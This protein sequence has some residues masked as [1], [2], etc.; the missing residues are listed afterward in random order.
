M[1]TQTIFAAPMVGALSAEHRHRVGRRTEARRGRHGF[2][3]PDSAWPSRPLPPDRSTRS[4]R[5]S[6]R[7]MPS[8]ARR[9]S[10][11]SPCI[12][13]RAVERVAVL[14]ASAAAGPASARRSGRSKAS[15]ILARSSRRCSA[16]RGCGSRGRDRRRSRSLRLFVAERAG[17]GGGRPA[18]G[19]HARPPP[20]RAGPPGRAAGASG[21]R[22]GDDRAA[23][24][25]AGGRSE[26]AVR[27]AA[28]APA[29]AAAGPSAIRST[30]S[31]GP[32]TRRC[33]T[34]RTRCGWPSPQAGGIAPLPHLLE[35]VER[36]A[37]TR[38]SAAAGR[39]G[40][41]WAPVRGAAHVALAEARQPARRLRPEGV[42][43]AGARAAAGRIPDGA[44]ARRRRLV[45][46]G[47]RGGAR[48]RARRVVARSSGGRVSR[49]RRARERSRGATR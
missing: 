36:V 40:D 17:S 22:G 3:I 23:A 30:R 13:A 19:G 48:G 21:S 12:G 34:I 24:D 33:R 43:R 31:P 41:D 11:G 6:R 15:P 9:R 44:V 37:R 45:P 26:P 4:L 18:D 46:R 28:A 35:I 2:V 49:D 39:R 29:R 25:V 8:S 1:M 7:R 47:D 42:A 38:G 16:A 27:G 20:A 14:A 32:P 10:R 5:T